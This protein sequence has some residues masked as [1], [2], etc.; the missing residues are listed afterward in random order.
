MQTIKVI[1]LGI[2]IFIGLVFFASEINAKLDVEINGNTFKP[3]DEVQLKIRIKNDYPEVKTFLIIDYISSED[4]AEMAQVRE[5]VLSPKE[6]RVIERN[7][8]VSKNLPSGPYKYLVSVSLDDEVIDNKTISFTI[9]GTLKRFK[10]IYYKTCLD[11]NCTKPKITFELSNSPIYL[12]VFETEGAIL[13]G[14]LTL[15]D[16]STSSLKFSDGLA[17]I[18][19]KQ[20]GKYSAEI[21]AKKQGYQDYTFYVEFDVVEKLPQIVDL[22]GICNLNGVCDNGENYQNCPQDCAY[23]ESSTKTKE[24]KKLNKRL[25]LIAG[26]LTLFLIVCVVVI[27]LVLRRKHKDSIES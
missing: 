12:K 9:T 24:E 18:K 26:L 1:F 16:S 5:I 10:N 20:T 27:I 14:A 3:G 19:L 4:Y 21:T 8:I 11:P 7:F 15:P 6:S 2:I 23:G 17:K 13:T 25:I 22:S